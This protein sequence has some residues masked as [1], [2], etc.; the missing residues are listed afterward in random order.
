MTR[1]EAV[2][3][4][5][6]GMT[7]R[8]K[9]LRI[10]ALDPKTGRVLWDHPASPGFNPPG[11]SPEVLVM[12][13]KVVYLQPFSSKYHFWTYIVVADARSGRPRAVSAD[14]FRID[15][16]PEKCGTSICFD[17][18]RDVAGG[19]VPEERW[20]MNPLTGAVRSSTGSKEIANGNWRSIGDGGLIE[21]NGRRR[22]I[23]RQVRGKLVW[24]RP[25][26]DLFGP[27]FTSD[28]GWEWE[29]DAKNHIFT[30]EIGWH[31]KDIR[32]RIE[33]LRTSS[34]MVGLDSRTGKLR[35]REVGVTRWCTA[36]DLLAEL[37]S[38]YEDYRCRYRSGTDDYRKN[39]KTWLKNVGVTVE[40]FNHVS[41]KVDWS[42]PLDAYTVSDDYAEPTVRIL[43]DDHLLGRQHRHVIAFDVH[44]GTTATM[45]SRTDGWC[46]FSDDVAYAGSPYKEA[47]KARLTGTLLMPCGPDGKETKI[48]GLPPTAL[49]AT[50][51]NVRAVTGKH[52]VTGL[53]TS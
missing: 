13:K 11:V 14:D 51:G 8:N 25:W 29:Y 49:S 42:V 36:A 9:L 35:W 21:V 44:D 12:G 40:R 19:D 18:Y 3:G 37:P 10:T 24:Q 39:V 4:V 2:D 53:R 27:D 50:I 1:F 38:G 17:G 23:G 6:V 28:S 30:G 22:G 34:I 31:P 26:R 48:T 43:D 46:A 47:G 15:G 7:L 45:S 41:N 20:V 5:L 16:L 33:H 52:A 32:K